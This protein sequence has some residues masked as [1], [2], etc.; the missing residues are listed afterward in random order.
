[1]YT[2]TMISFKQITY[3]LA[4][5]KTLHFKRAAEQCS[6]SQS[7]LSTALAEM[8]RQL[9]F[10]VF[11][12]DNKRV[13]V[14]PLGQQVLDKAKNIKLQLDDLHRLAETQKEPL[15][16]PVS[17]GAIPT[18]A[19]YILPQVLPAIQSEYPRLQLS[20]V[21]EQSHILVEMVKSGDLDT[22]ILALPY[23][24]EGLLTFEFW[25]E[26]FYWVTHKDDP[27]YSNRLEITSQELDHD[28]L[29]LLK[30]GHCLKDHALEACQ[31]EKATNSH[32]LRA[33]SLNT[34]IQLVAGGLGTTLAPQMA[35]KQLIA[36][37]SKLAAVHLNEKSPHRRIAFV[38]RPNYVRLADIEHLMKLFKEQLSSN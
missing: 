3:A 20:V 2:G 17:I 15:S 21:E 35:L 36:D 25:K 32:S 11:E 18:I 30:D 7:A 23:Q 29:M 31:F 19:P 34:L 6:V 4:V 9:G 16:Y 13:L 33:T 37:D 26:D 1:M 14:T 24:C 38:V 28:R 22:A 27:S 5:E 12:R 10:Q 8:E